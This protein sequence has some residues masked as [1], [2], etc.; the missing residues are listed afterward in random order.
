VLNIP[1]VQ[2]PLEFDSNAQ[3]IFGTYQRDRARFHRRGFFLGHS[4][5]AI[6]TE[7]LVRNGLERSPNAYR[8]MDF[9]SDHQRSVYRPRFAI[10]E[11]AGHPKFT[12]RKGLLAVKFVETAD[13]VRLLCDEVDTGGSVSVEGRALAVGAGAINSARIVLSSLNAF[14]TKIPLLSNPYNYIACVNL[15]ML[16]RP[17]SDRRH[18][19]SQLTGVQTIPGQAPPDRTIL[20]MYSYRSMLIFRLARE[21]PCPTFLGVQLA[22]LLQTSFT[23]VGVHQA[24]RHTPAKWLE[25]RKRA[26]GREVLAGHYE[27]SATE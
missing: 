17:A 18:S 15:R 22:R 27:F 4:P 2:R 3:S 13:R 7:P 12:Y 11:L 1:N 14:G 24:D 9:Y 6:L 10:E 21:M 16:G 19:M 5:S 23:I 8:D 26:D 20:S 25:L